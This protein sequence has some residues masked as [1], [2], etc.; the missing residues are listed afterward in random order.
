MDGNWKWLGG[1]S[2]KYVARAV[3]PGVRL[4]CTESLEE[5]YK[6]T[7][8]VYVLSLQFHLMRGC[9]VRGEKVMSETGGNIGVGSHFKWMKK[10][11]VTRMMHERIRFRIRS[12]Y[13]YQFVKLAHNLIK[14]IILAARQPCPGPHYS[15]SHTP[16][17][18]EIDRQREREGGSSFPQKTVS[19]SDNQK[20]KWR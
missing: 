2:A 9:N 11:V 6:F 15:Q 12:L 4:K 19:K 16:N 8:K 10:V 20:G 14:P 3:C 17:Q 5:L 1:R 13:F 18:T 7:E